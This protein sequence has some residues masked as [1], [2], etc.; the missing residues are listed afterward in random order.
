MHQWQ[1]TVLAVCIFG[2]N[3]ALI[4]TILSKHKPHASTGI[5]TAFFQL[6][7]FV[8]FVSL[9]LWYSAAMSLLNATL[10]TIIVVQKIS[11]PKTVKRKR[12]RKFA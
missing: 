12:T 9:G 3:V 11:K 6:A 5:M 8:V 1:D 4:P 7:T 10:W 2:F